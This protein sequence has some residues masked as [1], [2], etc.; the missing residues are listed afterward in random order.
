VS[1]PEQTPILAA[2]VW[3]R[4]L[5]AGQSGEWSVLATTIAPGCVWSVVT[6]GAVFRGRDEVIGFIRAGFDAAATRER[7]DVR[8]EFSTTESGVYE[9]TSRGTIDPNHAK[10]FARRLTGGRPI[11]TSGLAKIVGWA[12]SG[13]SFVVP[14]CFVY[15]V[16]QDGQ[17]DRVNEYVGK[18]STT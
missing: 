10:A 16:N 11:I 1:S 17:I 13:K 14:V 18:R 9:Y 7:P 8:G 5:K 2:E 3:D 6:Q 12:M 4:Q 15:H